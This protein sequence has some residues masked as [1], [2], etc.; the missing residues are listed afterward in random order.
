MKDLKLLDDKALIKLALAGRGECF[1]AL[2][3]RHLSALKSRVHAMVSNAAEAEDVVQEVQLKAWTYLSSF[4]CDCS[5]RT[6]ITRIAI[7]ESLQSHRRAKRGRRCEEFQLDSLSDSA[8]SPFQSYARLEVAGIVQNAIGRL[9]S[10]SRQILVLRDLQELS[11]KE[12]AQQ[13]NASIT[14]VKT[15]L[16]RA[17]VMLLKAL[18]RRH[19]RNEGARRAHK[20]PATDWR[21]G[22]RIMPRDPNVRAGG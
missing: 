7:N 6:W 5:F 12:T 17:R 16:F 3:H 20:L 4:R 15:R 18:Q 13:L 9:P 21:L 14:L 19:L 8:D 2:M 22:C 1:D 10:Q 11:I